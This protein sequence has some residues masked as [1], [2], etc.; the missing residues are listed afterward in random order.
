MKKILKSSSTSDIPYHPAS[1]PLKTQNQTFTV[2]FND[3]KTPTPKTNKKPLPKPDLPQF[4]YNDD[5]SIDAPKV[6]IFYDHAGLHGKERVDLS[7]FRLSR[8]VFQYLGSSNATLQQLSLDNVTHFQAAWFQSLRGKTSVR[9]LSVAGLPFKIDKELTSV[10]FSMTQLKTLNMRKNSFQDDATIFKEISHLKALT[11]LNLAHCEG[12]D[13]YAL[14]AI[15]ELITRGRALQS[16]D[17]TE[18][19][20]FRDEA[21]IELTHAG[22]NV[23][24]EVR[25]SRCAQLTSLALSGFNVKMSKLTTLS[26]HSLHHLTATVYSW[27]GQG[28]RQLTSLDVS[29]NLSLTDAALGVL[30]KNC[31]ALTHLNLSNCLTLTDAGFELFFESFLGALTSLNLNNCSNLSDTTL[32]LIVEKQHATSLQSLHLNSLSRVT[33]RALAAFFARAGGLSVFEMCCEL[34]PVSKSRTSTVPHLSDHSLHSL[35]GAPALRSF[36]AAGAIVI[37]DDGLRALCTACRGLVRLNLSFCSKITNQAMKYVAEGLTCLTSLN[38]TACIYIS[39]VGIHALCQGRLPLQALELNGC[40]KITDVALGLLSRHFSTSL[41]HLALRSCDL[42]TDEGI[43]QLA[44]YCS[45][46]QFLDISNL[47]YVTINAVQ[48]LA[49]RCYRLT[50]LHCA[51]CGFTSKELQTSAAR[52][53]PFARPMT[54]T[55]YELEPRQ[56]S[57]IHFNKHLLYMQGVHRAVHTLMRFLRIIQRY[58]EVLARKKKEREEK[59]L[60][61]FYFAKLQAKVSSRLRVR[62]RK[63]RVH[64]VKVI[65]R[66]FR[67]WYTKR[68]AQ[69]KLRHLRSSYASAVTI[70]RVYRGFYARKR[71]HLL[72]SR[73][74]RVKDFFVT[75]VGRYFLVFHARALRATVIRLQNFCRSCL[76]RWKFTLFRKALAL[77]QIKFKAKYSSMRRKYAK[78]VTAEEIARME[79]LRRQ[80]AARKILRNWKNRMF[81]AQ[82]TSFT[83]FCALISRSEYEDMTWSAKVVQKR[84]RGYIVRLKNYRRARMTERH[85]AAA[86]KIQTW[87]RSRH[88][89]RTFRRVIRPRFRRIIRHYQRLAK[90]RA[91][92]LR[93]GGTVKR[94][95]R[96]YRLHLF[97]LH[98][99]RAGQAILGFYR[100]QQWRM[101]RRRQYFEKLIM[102]ARL[103]QSHWKA[104]KCRRVL[105]LR[106]A[107]KHMAAFKIYSKINSFFKVQRIQ[108]QRRLE[109]QMKRMSIIEMKRQKLLEKRTEIVA[110]IKRRF[111]NLQA[112]KI[113]RAWHAHKMALRKAEEEK[114]A[115]EKKEVASDDGSLSLIALK[116]VKGA[117][118]GALAILQPIVAVAEGVAKIGKV[119]AGTDL[120]APSEEKKFSNA[121]LKY[122]VK[123]ILQEGVTEL[124]LTLG[125]HE[126]KAFQVSQTQLRMAKLPHFVRLEQDLSGSMALD[127]SLWVQYGTGREC[128]CQLEVT[129]KPPH[130][131]NAQMKLRQTELAG[132]CVKLVWHPQIHFEMRGKC[133]AK[134]GLADFAIQEV[135]ICDTAEG[136]ESLLKDGFMLLKDLTQIGFAGISLWGK[137]KK[138]D[139][140]SLLFKF[141]RVQSQ[142]WCD[143][144]LLRVMKAFNITEDDVMRLHRVF[145]NVLYGRNRDTMRVEELFASIDF[146][147]NQLCRWVVQAVR[148]SKR[149]ELKFSEYAH[150]VSYYIMLSPRDLTRFLFQHADDG[151]KAYLRRDQFQKLLELLSQDSPFNLKT[152]EVQYERFHDKKLKFQFIKNFED[153]VEK[154]PGSLWKP[155]LLQQKLMKANLG[156]TYWEKKIEQ[157]R[158][159]RENMG[160]RLV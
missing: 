9:A 115:R 11:S 127:I 17:L 134:L 90:V 45:L 21:L 129:N 57:V 71:M 75:I 154:N 16:I 140:E 33:D 118:K 88:M 97:R 6:L 1:L 19:R 107:R 68:C 144:R 125:E 109:E 139:D 117:G 159:T 5:S 12:I 53:L 40:A 136:A 121:V 7:G 116:K 148:P 155:Q 15:A 32:D 83:L 123:S 14:V 51:G 102:C 36:V 67:R 64:A 26:M 131:S 77:L 158:I 80:E 23:L 96:A 151:D 160:V 112:S 120:I 145:E 3:R 153:F 69:R 10:I 119:L 46:L 58:K 35:N 54:G 43:R 8:Q 49:E 124:A 104:F 39:D 63:R 111:L 152:W 103:I 85:M 76:T 2:R 94:I 128:I 70:Q 28:C 74:R 108:R 98:R 38:L 65:Q 44:R 66:T 41:H 133:S 52:L 146:P 84:W 34:R 13:D 93:L 143:D 20:P 91:P 50:Q 149:A 157:Y 135:Q 31:Q 106:K 22:M 29:G 60:L 147:Y 142:P 55:K 130:T 59:A 110:R 137:T 150:L 100:H 138:P 86:K 87:W 105:E 48:S 24:T 73:Q 122:Q 92:R 99:F 126:A 114:L 4:H 132:Q 79:Q 95:Q 42:I 72:F 78:F 156:V 37:G 30:G 82:M 47:D 81:N 18:A 56:L 101:R 62:Q 141:N 25:V 27:L 89:L 113:Q 61:A